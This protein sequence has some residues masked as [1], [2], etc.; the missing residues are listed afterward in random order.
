M[1]MLVIPSSHPLDVQAELGGGV[2]RKALGRR[3][4]ELSITAQRRGRPKSAPVFGAGEDP[5]TLA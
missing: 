1:I 4:G 2:V 5:K 3:V